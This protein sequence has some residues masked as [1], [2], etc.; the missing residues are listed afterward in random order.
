MLPRH[1]HFGTQLV[2]SNSIKP[3]GKRHQL[4]FTAQSGRQTWGG[5]TFARPFLPVSSYW[6]TNVNFV[7]AGRMV[8]ELESCPVT[9]IVYVPVGGFETP[10]ETLLHPEIANPIA[11]K[12]ITPAAARNFR[13]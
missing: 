11:T 6:M 13:E 4:G 10:L 9:V 2:A 12:A 1:G 3:L 7:V 8:A 5:R